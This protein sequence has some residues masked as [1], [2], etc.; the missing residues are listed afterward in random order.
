MKKISVKT[1][2]IV[3]SSLVLLLS[4]VPF[5]TAELEEVRLPSM[6]ENFFFATSLLSFMV[7]AFSLVLLDHRKNGDRYKRD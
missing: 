3:A 5:Y 6:V 2:L 1:F 4:I 7:L